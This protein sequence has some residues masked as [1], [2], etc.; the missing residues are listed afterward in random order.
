[1]PVPHK[2]QEANQTIQDKWVIHHYLKVF[3]SLLYKLLMLPLV[4]F[5]L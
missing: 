5:T 2:P 3:A 4:L 1:M